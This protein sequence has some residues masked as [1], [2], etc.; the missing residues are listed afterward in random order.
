MPPAR[1]RGPF[2]RGRQTEV[3]GPAEPGRL[4]PRPAQVR[5]RY[6]ASPAI[7]PVIVGGGDA[8]VRVWRLADGTPA[9]EPLRGHRGMVKAVAVGALR[10]PLRS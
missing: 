7:A 1:L 6:T 2:R 3:K 10:M 8:T 5:P 4:R 9:G